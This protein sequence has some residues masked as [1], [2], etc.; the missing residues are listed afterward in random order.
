MIP[1]AQALHVGGIRGAYECYEEILNQPDYF[2]D[3]YDLITLVYQLLSVKKFDL[4]KEVLQLNL[5]AFPKH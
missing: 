1:I 2:S 4:A 5:H 3:P